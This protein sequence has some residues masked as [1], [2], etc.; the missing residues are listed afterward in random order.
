LLDS[1]SRTSSEAG[2]YLYGEHDD[3]LL[4]R[5]LSPVPDDSRSA[6][7]PHCTDSPLSLFASKIQPLQFTPA[8]GE[9]IPEFPFISSLRFALQL[10]LQLPKTP[11]IENC[12]EFCPPTMGIQK[13][14]KPS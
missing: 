11:T 6:A 3:E 13:Q 5:R 1:P 4:G 14:N 2:Q 12:Q 7:A 8:D 10:S 9:H